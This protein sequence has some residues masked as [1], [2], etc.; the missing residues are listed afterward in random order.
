MAPHRP[1]RA[2]GAAKMTGAHGFEGHP[3]RDPLLVDVMAYPSDAL[4]SRL[5]TGVCVSSGRRT[6]RCGAIKPSP[7]FHFPAPAGRT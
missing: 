4:R 3:P 1:H 6:C 7:R 2:D 5:G